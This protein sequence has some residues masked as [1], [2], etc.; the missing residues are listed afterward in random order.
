MD[1]KKFN[2]QF[3][4]FLQQCPTPFHTTEYLRKNFQRAGFKPLL[5]N[6][7]WH[8]ENGKG[9]YCTRDDGTIIAL[10]LASDSTKSLPW[11]MTGA[12]SDSPSLQIKPNPVRETHSLNQLCVEVYGGP[13]LAT[14][15]DRDL[16]IAG[17]V[18][19]LRKDGT[20]LTRTIDFK[21]PVAIIPSLAIHLDRKANKEHT[22][23]KQK[24]LYPLFCQSIKKGTSFDDI[25]LGQVKTEYPDLAVKT[26]LGFDLFCYDTQPPAFI[27]LNNDFIAASRLDNLVSCFVGLKALLQKN[28]ADNCLLLCSNHEE[29]G[30]SS[31]AG[32]QG[33]FLSSVLERLVPE[34]SLRSRLMSNS[35]FLSLD[36]AHAV[37][38]NFTE[39]HDPQHFP[40]LNHGPVIK[41]NSNQ[42]YAT[43][44]RSAGFYKTLSSEVAVPVQTFVMNNDMAC[45]STI[46]PIAATTLGVHTVDIGIPSLAMHSI[47]ETTGTKDPYMLYQTIAHF[48]SRP[49]LPQV[50]A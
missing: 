11:R 25:L 17:R 33:N 21:K 18:A 10:K 29:I 26:L 4:D 15:F 49:E 19:L 28:S 16:G 32:A 46:G 48:Y 31:V 27:G 41:Y 1:L 35:Y 42:R 14:W 7:E 5:E 50:E 30:S 45:G 22:V 36:N 20:L 43:T 9:Y 6:D 13:L 44:S 23:E 37:H 38:P 34:A 40:L 39:K 24:Q 8:V 3:F 12:H 2:Q 47:R